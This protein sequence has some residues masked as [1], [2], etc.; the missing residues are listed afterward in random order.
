MNPSRFVLGY[1]SMYRVTFSSRVHGV[2]LPELSA[3]RQVVGD[4]HHKCKHQV[5]V[6]MRAHSAQ[7]YELAPSPFEWTLDNIARQAV[8]T[9]KHQGCH[10]FAMPRKYRHPN[11]PHGLR[12][13]SSQKRVAIPPISQ[14]PSELSTP[15]IQKEKTRQHT[16]YENDAETPT[17]S[18][19]HVTQNPSLADSW[20]ND[21]MCAYVCMYVCACTYVCMYVLMYV[22]AHVC[23]YVCICE[24]MYVCT[25]VCRDR[26]IYVCMY[27]GMHE[28]LICLLC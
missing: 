20:R 22:R 13:P 21:S 19:D 5:D 26:C 6:P 3:T 12:P 4:A 23:I 28:T 14:K 11:Y 27:V 24:C 2:I 7:V 15:T 18:V 8:G 16:S 17:K 10:M 1:L 9:G 25:Y